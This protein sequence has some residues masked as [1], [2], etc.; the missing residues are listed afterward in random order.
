MEGESER[1]GEGEN[2][3]WL[4]NSIFMFPILNFNDP[5]FNL[6]ALTFNLSTLSFNLVPLN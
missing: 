4:N 6:S 5:S 2:R 3:R 1:R